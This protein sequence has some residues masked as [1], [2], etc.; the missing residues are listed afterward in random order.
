MKL[1]AVFRD[2]V[3]RAIVANA[4]S[5]IGTQLVT[6]GL[7]FIFWLVA[8]RWFSPA[9]VGFAAAAI[10][11]MTLLGTFGMLGL[12]TLLMGELPRRQHLR[13]P[14]ITTALSTAG[15]V[16]GCLGLLFTVIAPHLS[17]DLAPLFAGVPN[18][19]VFTLGVAVGAISLVIDSVVIGLLR[20]H[21]QLGRNAIFALAKLGA[22]LAVGRWLGD[23]VGLA[24]L[25]TWVAG[26]L[27]SLALI[28]GLLLRGANGAAYRPQLRLLAGLVGPALAHHLLNLS[29][30]FPGLALPVLVT[31]ILSARLNAA[32]Y[33]AWNV[34]AFLFVVPSALTNVLYA[35]GSAS[36]V[37]SGKRVRFTLVVSLLLGLLGSGLI[38]VGA[39]PVLRLF[40]HSYAQQATWPLRILALGV[41]PTI[42]KTHYIAISRIHRRLV[43]GALVLVVGGLLELLVASLG[44]IRAGLAGLAAGWVL[45]VC[46]EAIVMGRA[47][48]REARLTDP[49]AAQ[50][51][52]SVTGLI[53]AAN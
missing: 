18:A 36:P 30:Q 5:L 52:S 13:G 2:R 53:A 21:L 51:E 6:S 39:D 27:L 22:L 34:L 28:G 19:T 4:G 44:A 31:V 10:S 33:V 1:I 15:L 20:G 26:N 41:F 46:L 25:T 47:V 11:A 23:S 24:I 38:V 7:G 32:F 16:G 37:E 50:Q 12:G 49:A 35:V 8:A 40:G 29:I 3:N 43:G 45:A 17:H 48:Y 14:L 42:V 9:A